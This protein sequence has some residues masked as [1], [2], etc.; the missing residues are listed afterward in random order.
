MRE[1][2]G[3]ARLVVPVLFAVW[4]NTHGGW[5]VGAGILAIFTACALIDLTLPLRLRLAI[6]LDGRRQRGRAIFFG[7]HTDMEKSKEP[8]IQEFLELD[9]LKLE[10]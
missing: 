1:G 5:L 6:L 10:A 7:T 8:I 3:W 2:R 9:E 4:V